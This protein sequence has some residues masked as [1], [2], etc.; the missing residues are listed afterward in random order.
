MAD[1]PML[2]GDKI[3]AGTLQEKR[4]TRE[5]WEL[6]FKADSGKIERAIIPTCNPTMVL[7]TTAQTMLEPGVVTIR[8]CAD[9]DDFYMIRVDP[10]DAHQT[11]PRLISY[12]ELKDL[13]EVQDADQVASAAASSSHDHRTTPD[14]VVDPGNGR[15]P[16]PLSIDRDTIP[17][18]LR[19][20]VQQGGR[21][22]RGLF[23]GMPIAIEPPILIDE[24]HG[25]DEFVRSRIKVTLSPAQ[26]QY[27]REAERIH[28]DLLQRRDPW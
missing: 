21:I 22:E 10:G 20:R 5:N 3:R 26:K 16:V 23:Q 1:R 14:F 4:A 13:P 15:P 28:E 24:A 7:T 8:R 6:L 12:D 2:P 27:L 25:A 9:R 17:E 19:P 18:R 11:M